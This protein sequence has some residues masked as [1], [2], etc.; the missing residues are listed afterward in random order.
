MDQKPA[1]SLWG[2]YTKHVLRSERLL[3]EQPKGRPRFP[4]HAVFR[5]LE[6]SQM[7]P[8]AGDGLCGSGQA[9]LAATP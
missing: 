1:G 8:G 2:S 9:C 7:L 4:Q 6:K 3:G 5:A